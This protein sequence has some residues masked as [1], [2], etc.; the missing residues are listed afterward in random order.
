MADDPKPKQ[1][2]EGEECSEDECGTGT[3]F[4]QPLKHPILRSV[5]PVKVADFL[6]EREIYEMEIKEKQK[7]VPS[8]SLASY[9]VSN[10]PGLLRR[11]H[12]LGRF[13]KIAPKKSLAQLTSNHI[14]KWIQS[15]VK[16]EQT[17]F[18]PV[19]V[20]R[21]L[22][23]L[24]T[25]M[26]I[27][28]PEARIMEY[29]NDF[30]N[31][32]EQVGY[33]NLKDVNPKKTISLLQ[34][35]LYPI[36]FKE[37]MI[38]SLEYHENLKSDVN[39][40]V[41]ILIEEAKAFEKYGKDLTKQKFNGVGDHKKRFNDKR[42]NQDESKDDKQLP[43]CLNPIHKAQHKRCNIWKC[44]I[45]SKEEA[46]KLLKEHREEKSKRKVQAVFDQ[47]EDQT[48]TE[49]SSTLIEAK[50][51]DSCNRVICADNGGYQHPT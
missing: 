32:L 10:D 27:A 8:L 39:C 48:D 3:M 13:N 24:R 22:A 26:N 45:T 35:H 43:I 1:R 46:R 17:L 41:E 15:L 38:K 2:L 25:P 29:L 11:M 37:V 36:R 50:F 4:F 19:V 16:R 47:N 34:Q 51:G 44:E 5:D 18:D 31:R 14:E 21:C 9:R 23:K 7:E 6:R 33:D 30:F 12:F 28:D 49:E 40:Y 42:G 20:E